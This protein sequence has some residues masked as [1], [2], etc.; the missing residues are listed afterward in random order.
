MDYGYYVIIK[1][2]IELMETVIVVRDF[3]SDDLPGERGERRP[4]TILA[5]GTPF[6]LRK[7]KYGGTPFPLSKTRI[8][9]RCSLYTSKPTKQ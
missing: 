1:L 6:P 3:S 5:Q 7:T 4:L 9:E 2:L 8:G